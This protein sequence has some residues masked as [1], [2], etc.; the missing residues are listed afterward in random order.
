[1]SSP[2]HGSASPRATVDKFA[3]SARAEAELIEI[4]DHSATQFGPYQAEAYLAGLERIFGLL[5][6]FP[7]IGQ[8]ADDLA[9]GY[10]RFR[11]Q[12]HPRVLYRGSRP[13]R[14]PRC[15]T[16]VAR[17]RPKSFSPAQFFRPRLRPR[18]PGLS[19][20]STKATPRP[21]PIASSSSIMPEMTD[22]PPSQNFG[23]LASSPNGASSSE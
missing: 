14:Y 3:L 16:R 20:G 22:S 17:T 15:H 10:R 2:L 1:M 21:Q 5:A 19:S 4:Y 23:S 9:P 18:G 8:P 12:S 6:D 11:F 13:G 7:K